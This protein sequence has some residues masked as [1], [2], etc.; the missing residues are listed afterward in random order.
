M[1]KKLIIYCCN[2]CPYFDNQYYEYNQ[3]CE[4]LG[5]ENKNYQ[6]SVLENCPLED[7]FDVE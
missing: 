5:E 3:T 6:S 1:G 7:E 2:D 4:R